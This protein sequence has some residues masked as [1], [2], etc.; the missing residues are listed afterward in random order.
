MH[1]PVEPLAGLV[2][3]VVLFED[4]GYGEQDQRIVLALLQGVDALGSLLRLRA[5]QHFFGPQ[6]AFAE[7]R[8]NTTLRAIHSGLVPVQ[9]KYNTNL[10]GDIL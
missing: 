6:R 2:D 1:A 4:S 9:C 8:T 7:E 10:S 5:I 3:L